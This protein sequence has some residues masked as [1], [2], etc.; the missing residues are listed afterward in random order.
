M[1]FLLFR[2]DSICDKWF[3]L[4]APNQSLLEDA[5]YRQGRVIPN[6]GV[7]KMQSL[8]FELDI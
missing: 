6:D 2:G 8:C 7:S 5:I 1:E 4:L 3:S